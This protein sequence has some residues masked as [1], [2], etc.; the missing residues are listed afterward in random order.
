M[1]R[2]DVDWNEVVPKA[3]VRLAVGVAVGAAAGAVLFGA[4]PSRHA[5]GAA[6][7]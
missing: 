4:R 5:R 7:R 2:S 6:R 3:G 1:P